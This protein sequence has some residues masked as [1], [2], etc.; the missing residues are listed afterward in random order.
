MNNAGAG[1]ACFSSDT[2]RS[3]LKHSTMTTLSLL[4]SS[5][6]A[7]DAPAALTLLPYLLQAQ[8]GSQRKERSRGWIIIS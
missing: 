7:L 3:S 5:D 2:F 1:S 4:S 8:P 6:E